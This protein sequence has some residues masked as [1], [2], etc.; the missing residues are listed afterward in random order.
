[1]R[2]RFFAFVGCLIS[3]DAD[4]DGQEAT[5]RGE[6]VDASTAALDASTQPVEVPDVVVDDSTLPGATPESADAG[7]VVQVTPTLDG[8][9]PMNSP[10]QG[11][12][13]DS[14]ASSFVYDSGAVESREQDATTGSPDTTPEAGTMTLSP[15][16]QGSRDGG[17][18]IGAV[19]DAAAA[20]IVWC[21]ANVGSTALEEGA[22]GEP[23]ACG[24]FGA[25]ETNFAGP[26]G[27]RYSITPA[28]N[29]QVALSFQ[30]ITGGA[31]VEASTTIPAGPPL[32]LLVP[33]A[34]ALRTEYGVNCS[35]CA[36][37][38]MSSCLLDVVPSEP[39]PTDNDAYWSAIVDLAT[40]TLRVRYYD[41]SL[42]SG[43]YVWELVDVCDQLS[44]AGSVPA[45]ACGD[46]VVD[47]EEAC[48]DGNTTNTDGC[49]NDCSEPRCGDGI[50]QAG[51]ECDEDGGN[52]NTASNACRLDCTS[53]VCG[54]G[55]VDDSEECD[56][57]SDNGPGGQCTSACQVFAP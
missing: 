13:L 31:T 7:G 32:L 20:P 47:S 6:I 27:I 34:A 35:G 43:V 42:A 19:D 29:E 55:V 49:T 39:L 53:P 3:C 21:V 38:D 11:E 41:S 46:G 9:A 22:W 56:D 33:T 18:A 45:P 23:G 52:S 15:D 54:D 51:E 5:G 37:S 44:E 26:V 10:E 48:D 30:V 57:G 25:Y 50:V 24:G 8:S 2:L 40:L 14:S 4:G 16:A 28:L 17:V 12:R 1:M 36:P